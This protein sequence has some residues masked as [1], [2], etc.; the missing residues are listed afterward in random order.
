[1]HFGYHNYDVR[2]VKVYMLCLQKVTC[3]LQYMCFHIQMAH[4]FHNKYWSRVEAPIT[5]Q[6]LC[7]ISRIRRRC[8][9]FPCRKIEIMRTTNLLVISFLKLKYCEFL[10]PKVGPNILP[11]SKVCHNCSFP[12]LALKTKTCVMTLLVPTWSKCSPNLVKILV[13]CRLLV[14]LWSGIGTLNT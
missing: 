10:K 2:E 7:Q 5:N 8:K 12:I 13:P 3:Q 6:M 1:M 11:M 14:R 9:F 4:Q